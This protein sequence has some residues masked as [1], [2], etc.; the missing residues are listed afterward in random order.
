MGREEMQRR[1]LLRSHGHVGDV[2]PAVIGGF[3]TLRRRVED[4]RTHC[5]EEGKARCTPRKSDSTVGEAAFR[6]ALRSAGRDSAGNRDGQSPWPR[7]ERAS[8]E[9]GR[10][11]RQ[12]QEDAQGHPAE[13][14]KVIDTTNAI[15]SVHIRLRKITKNRG[16]FPS[17]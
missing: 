12:R 10:E 5:P 3:N 13:I 2:C 6:P 8:R 17:D 14:R 1:R 9:P 15:E 11:H 4:I 16:S 7:Q